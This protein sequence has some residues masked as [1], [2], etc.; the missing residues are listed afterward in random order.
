MSYATQSQLA[1]D[2]DF[3]ARCTACAAR[4][5]DPASPTSS[6]SWV[7]ANIWELAATPGFDDKYEYAINSQ[8]SR[9]GWDGAVITDGDILAAIQ[10]LLAK[11][12][13][14]PVPVS[15]EPA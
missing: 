4:E 13:A 1:R 14:D 2:Q 5:I 11:V 8:H 10:A 12:P 7:I 3:I 6:Q 15:E 9:P